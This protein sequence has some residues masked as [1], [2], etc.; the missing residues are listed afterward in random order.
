MFPIKSNNVIDKKNIIRQLVLNASRKKAE[1]KQL[2]NLCELQT[3]YRIR[4][5]E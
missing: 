3:K 4:H 1:V 2:Q 5:V